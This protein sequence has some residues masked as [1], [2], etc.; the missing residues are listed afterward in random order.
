MVLRSLL[1]AF[2]IMMAAP[3]TAQELNF[4]ITGDYNASFLLDTATPNPEFVFD[5]YSFSISGITGFPNA[6]TGVADLTFF[7]ASATGGLLV[8]DPAGFDYL[9]DAN[10]AQLYTGNEAA[11]R[12]VPGRFALTGLSTPGNFVLSITAVPEPASWAMMLSGLALTGCA[13]RI[14]RRRM[15]PA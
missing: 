12:F 6:T 4:S 8:S 2:L 10:G 14:R 1:T 9:F 5:G 7:N 15:R 3:A 13:L 11:P